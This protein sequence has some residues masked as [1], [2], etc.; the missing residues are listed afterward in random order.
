[1]QRVEVAVVT[2]AATFTTFVT[3]PFQV[4][5]DG[6]G[7]EVSAVRV[8]RT[9]SVLKVFDRACESHIF[10]S[11]KRDLT[12]TVL[13]VSDEGLWDLYN[14][15]AAGDRYDASL[16]GTVDQGKI[17][18]DAECLRGQIVMGSGGE[19][20]WLLR[21]DPEGTVRTSFSAS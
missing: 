6:V 21:F 16:V 13:T 15:C 14:T 10:P 20:R 2:T 19:K 18:I 9:A 7:F 3:I 5:L 1:M 12:R 11:R 17:S 4:S 8:F